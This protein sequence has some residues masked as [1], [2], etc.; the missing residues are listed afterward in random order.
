[1]PETAALPS[2]VAVERPTVTRTRVNPFSEHFPIDEGAKRWTF[3]AATEADQKTLKRAL[4]QLRSAGKLADRTTRLVVSDPVDGVVT[5]D[6]WTVPKIVH[7]KSK[8]PTKK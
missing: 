8:T 2:P 5:V 4:S 3:P 6:V 1:M 7:T